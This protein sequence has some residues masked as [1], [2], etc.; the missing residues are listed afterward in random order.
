MD[1]ASKIQSQFLNEDYLATNIICYW[2][3]C[4]QMS[5]MLSKFITQNTI[6]LFAGWKRRRILRKRRLRCRSDQ[7]NFASSKKL[8]FQNQF[9][10]G[11]TLPTQQSW[12][13]L[14]RKVY[15]ERNN[16]MVF[17][18]QNCSDL[19]WE[20]IVLVIEKT[21]EIRG[22]RSRICKKIEITRTIYSNSERS[23]QFLVTECFFNLFL[24]VSHI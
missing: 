14:P 7:K 24:E 17:C 18:Y 5:F 13:M 3:V 19:Q 1:L 6:I 23:E 21:F 2:I 22:W 11:G 9:P 16:K 20:K 4:L 10:W 15:K 12:G 8:W